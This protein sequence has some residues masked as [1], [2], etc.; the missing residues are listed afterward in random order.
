[1][2]ESYHPLNEN[3]MY[4]KYHFKNPFSKSFR[5]FFQKRLNLGSD[6][7]KIVAT[8]EPDPTQLASP[9]RNPGDARLILFIYIFITF[10][11][12]FK[13]V[14]T[15]IP[16]STR[17]ADPNWSPVY[18]DIFNYLIKTFSLC[19]F[20]LGFRFARKH[21]QMVSPQT[22]TFHKMQFQ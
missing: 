19:Y 16:G 13:S 10:S 8:P 6:T 12:F 3:A 11:F 2:S 9:S 18:S 4:L 7:T 1:M 21:F 15:R 22:F 5:A 17:R 20:S 14:A